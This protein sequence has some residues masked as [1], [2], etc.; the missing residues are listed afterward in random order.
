MCLACY[1]RLDYDYKSGEYQKVFSGCQILPESK[2]IVNTVNLQHKC[3]RCYEPLPHLSMHPVSLQDGILNA[4]RPVVLQELGYEFAVYLCNPCAHWKKQT[5]RMR[6]VT[7]LKFPAYDLA[8]RTLYLPPITNVQL[9]TNSGQAGTKSINY[10][11]SMLVNKARSLL[12]R[13]KDLASLSS[14]PT[15]LPG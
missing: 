14:P 2:I 4:A 5:G 12:N 7:T 13:F 15:K 9:Q 1:R 10:P 3:F 11:V 8:T 6:E